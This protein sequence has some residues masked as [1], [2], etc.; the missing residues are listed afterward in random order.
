MAMASN[1][2]SAMTV[3]ST[4][5]RRIASQEDERVDVTK[6]ASCRL[7]RPDD[8]VRVGKQGTSFTAGISAETVGAQRLC[9]YR[10]TIPPGGSGKPHLHADHETALYILSG[11]SVCWY[12]EDLREMVFT[13][14]GDFL[15]IP[16]GT[17][18]LPA[19]PSLT[20]PCIALAAR[21]DPSDQESVVL[22]TVLNELASSLV[23]RLR[24]DPASLGL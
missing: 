4:I 17:P 3:D 18:H 15:Y 19:N 10:L 8:N 23:R 5:Q 14:A 24:E 11:E 2:E 12:G 7:I 6:V 13:R 1:V 16:A 21:T 22:L 9:L 20:E